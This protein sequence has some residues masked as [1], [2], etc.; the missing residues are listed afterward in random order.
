[1][2]VI[3]GLLGACPAC[4]SD[5]IIKYG[6]RITLSKGRYQRFK[7]QTCGSTFGP[8]DVIRCPSLGCNSP[9]V[10]KGGSTYPSSHDTFF[11]KD[12]GAIFHV[13]LRLTKTKHTGL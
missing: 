6:L 3:G 10:E 1:M 12:C 5:H 11:C 2:G 13:Q 8:E 7:C 9:N 4:G